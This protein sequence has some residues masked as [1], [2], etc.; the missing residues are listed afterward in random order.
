MNFGD[1]VYVFDIPY[2]YTSAKIIYKATFTG[3]I[4]IG[5]VECAEVELSDGTRRVIAIEQVRRI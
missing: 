1:I 3:I 2:L 4:K 5:F